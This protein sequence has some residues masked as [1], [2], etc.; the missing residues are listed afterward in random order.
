MFSLYPAYKKHDDDK[1]WESNQKRI[2]SV[3]ARARI[4]LLSIVYV[5]NNVYRAHN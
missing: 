4:I 1:Q 2:A 3:I 5:D